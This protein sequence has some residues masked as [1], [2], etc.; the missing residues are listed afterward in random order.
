MQ[1]KQ[2]YVYGRVQGVAFRYFTLQ[3]AKKIGVVGVVRN[4]LDGCVEVIAGGSEAQLAALKAWLHQGSPAA[5]V[6]RV[7]EQDYHGRTN[8]DGFKIR[9]FEEMA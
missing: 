9:I 2:Y 3:E 6:E 5:K 1:F 4:C 7:L 8:F